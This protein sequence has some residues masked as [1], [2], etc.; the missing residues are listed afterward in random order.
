MDSMWEVDEAEKFIKEYCRD[1]YS[2]AALF[3]HLAYTAILSYYWYV[4]ALYRESCGAV[5]GES[6]YNW[7]MMARRYS[8]F[9]VNKY[10]L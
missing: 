8:N 1:D 2:E 10:D 5:M 4:W 3:H 9:L 6:L 7:Q